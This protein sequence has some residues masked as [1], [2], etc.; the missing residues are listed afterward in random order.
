MKISKGE[1]VKKGKKK[2]KLEHTMSQRR[3]MRTSFWMKSSSNTAA[4]ILI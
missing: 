1:S 2:F 4:N 3:L